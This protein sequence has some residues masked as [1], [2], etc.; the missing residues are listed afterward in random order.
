MFNFFI[1]Q[2]KTII[3]TLFIIDKESRIQYIKEN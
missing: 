3:P 1:L 2:I